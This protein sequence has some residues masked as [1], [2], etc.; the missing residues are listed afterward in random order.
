MLGPNTVIDE[1]ITISK[2]WKLIQSI[3]GKKL[4]HARGCSFIADWELDGCKEVKEFKPKNMKPCPTC[5]KMVFVTL[6]AKDFAKNAL[7]YKKIFES[8]PTELIVKFFRDSHAKVSLFG[9]KLY[10]HCRQ[11]DW[12]ID[13]SF[14][15]VHLFHNNYKVRKRELGDHFAEVG[16]HE[17]ELEKTTS[18]AKLIEAIKE[19]DMYRFEKAEQVHARQRK[20]K[21]KM[22]FSEYDEEYWGL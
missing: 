22:T 7:R 8:V 17:H 11:D 20:K 4:V 12:Y 5:G 21:T 14:D 19:I 15:E 16:F 2:D 13:L 9:D 18:A 10:I 6:G 1:E 3:G